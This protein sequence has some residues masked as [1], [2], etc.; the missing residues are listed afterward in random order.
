MS[1]AVAAAGRFLGR[2]A[3]VRRRALEEAVLG[4]LPEVEDV[5]EAVLYLL[6]DAARVVTGEVLR[7]DAGRYI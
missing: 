2:V 4:R 6:S 1:A 7:V 5:A 3:L